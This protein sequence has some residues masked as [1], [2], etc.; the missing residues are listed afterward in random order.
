MLVAAVAVVGFSISS[1]SADASN[2]CTPKVYYKTIVVY[3]TIQTPVV[4]WV[5]VYDHCGDVYLKK[6]VS[7]KSVQVPVEKRVRIAY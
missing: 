5:K 3:E 6:V 2:Y 1:A 7:Y 4:N